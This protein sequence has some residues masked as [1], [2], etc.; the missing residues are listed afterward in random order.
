[1][2]DVGAAA[3]AEHFERRERLAQR[4]ATGGEVGRV[5]AVEGL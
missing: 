1:V 3:A 4:D 5:T 2:A